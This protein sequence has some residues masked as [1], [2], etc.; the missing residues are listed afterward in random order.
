MMEKGPNNSRES[1]PTQIIESVLGSLEL[2]G[3]NLAIAPLE[4]IEEA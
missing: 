3:S 1:M 2:E 4:S